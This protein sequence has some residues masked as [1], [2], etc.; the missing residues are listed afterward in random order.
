MKTSLAI[1]LAV[2]A[3]IARNR[4]ANFEHRHRWR[5]RTRQ[6]VPSRRV[7]TE[8]PLRDASWAVSRNRHASPSLNRRGR[9]APSIKEV[10]YAATNVRIG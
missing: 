1:M 4:G 10:R 8:C 3:T 6:V 7:P 2:A 9:L 5:G